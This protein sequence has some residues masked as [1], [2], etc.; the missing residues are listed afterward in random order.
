[1]LFI[2]NSFGYMTSKVNLD[3]DH[4]CNFSLEWLNARTQ[5]N[6]KK[7][8]N[9]GLRLKPGGGG[10][11]TLERGM[12]MCRGHDPLFSGQ[13][14][15]PSPPIY[16]QCA[17]VV[18]PFSIF[19]KFLHFQPCFGQNSS[20]LNPKFFKFSFPRPPFFKENSLPRPYILKPMWHTHTLKKSWVPPWGLKP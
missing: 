13:S 14:P 19:R 2:K 5:C 11:L 12:G 15:L 3:Q 8:Y 7:L 1:M 4:F 9:Q 20:C 16:H 17:A 10:A 18:P 6:Y